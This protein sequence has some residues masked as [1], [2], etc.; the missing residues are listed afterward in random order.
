[1]IKDRDVVKYM[2]AANDIEIVKDL[3]A[4]TDIEALCLCLLELY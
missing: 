2:K 4:T 3:E 1:M